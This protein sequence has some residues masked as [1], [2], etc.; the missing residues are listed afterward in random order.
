MNANMYYECR[1]CNRKFDELQRLGKAKFC[2]DHWICTDCDHDIT[3]DSKSLYKEAMELADLIWKSN[4]NEVLQEEYSAMRTK[5]LEE[6]LVTDKPVSVER[7]KISS[8][9]VEFE[10]DP[11]I[12]QYQ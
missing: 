5:A 11:R 10:V 4:E 9:P 2:E 7:V 8:M 3:K 1:K 12:N 6:R